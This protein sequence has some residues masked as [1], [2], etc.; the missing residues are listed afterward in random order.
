MNP[1]VLKFGPNALILAAAG[2]CAWPYTGEPPLVPPVAASRVKADPEIPAELLMPPRMSR[3]PRDPFQDPEVLRNEARARI[4][5][6]LKGLIKPKPDPKSGPR[7]DATAA[8]AVF[9]RVDPRDGMV[10]SATS[11]HG[12][13]GVAVINGKTYLAG[14]LVPC[15]G[16]TD[17]CVLAEVRPN[18][19]ILRHR[20]K[21]YPLDYPIH[22]ACA[23][24]D[25][26]ATADRDSASGRAPEVV[27]SPSRRAPVRRRNP[28]KN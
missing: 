22:P 23:P 12:R 7:T 2:A 1:S 5:A 9:V 8:G 15:T 4:S 24:R 6:L 28:P 26:A 16:A 27:R 18:Q 19:A 17:P 20:G 13:R 3:P 10:L 25:L 21:T 14:D 11:A